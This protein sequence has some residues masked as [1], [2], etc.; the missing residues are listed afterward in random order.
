MS[1]SSS[2]P[3][4]SL[5]LVQPDGKPFEVRRDRTGKCWVCSDDGPEYFLEVT[6]RKHLRDGIVQVNA[7]VDGKWMAMGFVV[8]S[9]SAPGHSFRIG[10]NEGGRMHALRFV[11]HKAQ[12]S[13]DDDDEAP[14]DAPPGHGTVKLVV[15]EVHRTEHVG[16]RLWTNE[17]DKASV[18]GAGRPVAT[19]HK[20]DV[21]SVT[22]EWGSTTVDAPSHRYEWNLRKGKH[23][24]E[25][26][27]Y[28]AT[29]FGLAV[30]GMY[31]PAPGAAAPAPPAQHQHD[32]SAA[33]RKRRRGGC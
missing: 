28:V 13:Q 1:S 8:D 21:D 10:L 33:A 2:S 14:E 19:G 23:I 6:L 9:R 29:D 22:S 7:Q 12:P 25:T 5:R 17:D 18:G 11:K 31:R 26:T 4:F 24:E 3:F 27:I 20:K 16:R 15:Y 32:C 30:R